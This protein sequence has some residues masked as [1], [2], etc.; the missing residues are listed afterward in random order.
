MKPKWRRKRPENYWEGDNG[1]EGEEEEEGTEPGGLSPLMFV[2]GHSSSIDVLSLM[3]AGG[4]K[5][6]KNFPGNFSVMLFVF[7]YSLIVGRLE[8]YCANH[9]VLSLLLHLVV[10]AMRTWT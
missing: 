8:G 4:G 5:Y 9:V 2:F 7:N 3:V 6:A 1:P 10:V